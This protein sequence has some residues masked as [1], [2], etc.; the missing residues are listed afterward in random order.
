MKVDVRQCQRC[1]HDHEVEARPLS[2]PTDQFTFWAM[3]PVKDEPLR[4]A[5]IADGVPPGPP[6]DPRRAHL[7]R[8]DT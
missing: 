3:C 1:G 5:V 7:L 8:E 2:N 4:I 6:A